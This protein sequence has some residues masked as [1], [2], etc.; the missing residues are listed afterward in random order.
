MERLVHTLIHKMLAQAKIRLHRS[1]SKLSQRVAQRVRGS[2]EPGGGLYL[3]CV[4]QEAPQP[5]HSNYCLNTP[6]ERVVF[7]MPGGEQSREWKD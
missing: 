7:L 2:G 6:F 4:V 5:L 1:P 3:D